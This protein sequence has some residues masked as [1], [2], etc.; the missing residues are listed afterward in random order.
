M[1]LSTEGLTFAYPESEPA[2]KGLSLGGALATL[3]MLFLVP[4]L[5]ARLSMRSYLPVALGL[6]GLAAGVL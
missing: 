3:G 2:L 4:W 1:G 6:C 5:A